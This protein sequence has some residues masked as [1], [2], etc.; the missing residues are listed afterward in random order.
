MKVALKQYSLPETEQ[1]FGALEQS[2]P[3][4]SFPGLT[5]TLVHAEAGL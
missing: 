2:I 4:E 3:K 5:L 1:E